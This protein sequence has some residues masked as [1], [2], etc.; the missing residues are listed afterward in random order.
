MNPPSSRALRDFV[1]ILRHHGI[2][3]TIQALAGRYGLSGRSP[4]LSTLARMARDMGFAAARRKLAPRRLLELGDAYPALAAARDGGTAM[5]SGVRAGP[6]GARELVLYDLE[7]GQAGSPFVFV[8]ENGIT[9]RFTGEVLL[10]RKKVPGDGDA[11]RF[12]LGW[13]LPQVAREKR[14]FLEIACIAFFMHGLAFAV[15]LYFQNVVDKVL[16]HHILST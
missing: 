6:A 9:D 15:P 2:Q 4:S 8:P 12:D 1:A 13:F 3:T 7:R 16:A 10:L 11:K 5:L 14:V